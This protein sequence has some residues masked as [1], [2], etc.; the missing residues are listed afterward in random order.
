MK[1]AEKII[2]LSLAFFLIHCSSENEEDLLPNNNDR[3][4]ENTAT[5]SENIIPI[6]N[7]NCAI[8]GCHVSGTGRADLSVKENIIQNATQIR[9]FTQNNFM[10]PSGSGLTLSAGQKEDIYCWVENGAQDN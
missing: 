2:M 4:E 8:S 3:C 7:Q 6:I 9:S 10:P 1:T 5:L